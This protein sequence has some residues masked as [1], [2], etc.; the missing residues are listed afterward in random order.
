ML[1]SINEA[2]ME[3]LKHNILAFIHM[4]TLF[5]FIRYRDT[6]MLPGMFMQVVALPNPRPCLSSNLLP[7]TKQLSSPAL[8]REEPFEFHEPIDTYGLAHVRGI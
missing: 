1:Y 8:P 4:L 3:S 2:A 7:A 6:R 5:V